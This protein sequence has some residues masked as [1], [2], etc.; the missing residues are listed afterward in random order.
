MKF[1]SFKKLVEIKKIRNPIWFAMDADSKPSDKDVLDA[2]KKLSVK[3][4]HD[5]VDF[6][7]EYGGGYFALANIFSLDS[8]SD[9][10]LVTQNFKN[11]VLRQGHILLS[12]NGA[13]DFYG[14]K[15]IDGICLA[16]IYFFDHELQK[17]VKTDFTNLFEY[18]E[19]FG[20]TN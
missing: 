3:L 17:W 12:D 10:H 19:Q 13:G 8:T 5:Y 20:L 15:V 11:D 16:E 1:D 2:E 7:G 18:L 14:F 9:W 4:P 6:I